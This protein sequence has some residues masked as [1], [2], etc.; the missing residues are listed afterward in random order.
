MSERVPITYSTK[1]PEKEKIKYKRLC[2]VSFWGFDTKIGQITNDST[3][4]YEIQ[5][6]YKKGSKEWEDLNI[7]LKL[8]RYFQG[9]EIDRAKGGYKAKKTPKEWNQYTEKRPYFMRYLYSKYN[10]QYKDFI[11]DIDRY[12]LIKFGKKY[13]DLNDNE[14]VSIE[15]AYNIKNPFIESNGVMNKVCRYMES[16]TKNI[17]NTIKDYDSEMLFNELY[18][19]KIKLDKNKLEMMEKIFNEYNDFKKSRQLIESEFADYEQYYKN[20]R[21]RCLEEISSNIKELA[22]LSVYI[23]YNLYPKKK[24]DFCWNVFGGGIVENL[25]TKSTIANIPVLS[26]FGEIDYLG[27][28]YFICATDISNQESDNE[29]GLLFEGE[30]SDDNI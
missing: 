21:N 2:E 15:E 29:I 3:T 17:K 24:K 22:N 16:C 6:N 18:N 5:S 14:K 23:C 1:K 4:V 19:D 13:K 7:V 10:K 28:K 9:N 20:L 26:D 30:E 12:C 27:K 8:F 11:E 25:K